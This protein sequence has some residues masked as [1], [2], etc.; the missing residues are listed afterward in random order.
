MIKQGCLIAL[1][2]IAGTIQPAAA[3]RWSHFLPLE[4]VR[5]IRYDSLANVYWL[6]TDNN[7]LWRFD[8]RQFEHFLPKTPE[9]RIINHVT[10]LTIDAK[11]A[12]L[13]VGT[14]DGLFRYHFLSNQWEYFNQDSGLSKNHVTAL[15][16]DR[17]GTLWYG[18]EDSNSS[19]GGVGK[20]DSTGWYRY[21]TAGY[22][23]WNPSDRVWVHIPE[24]EPIPSGPAARNNIDCIGQ[25]DSDKMYFGTRGT[26][27]CILDNTTTAWDTCFISFPPPARFYRYIQAIAIDRQG[28]KWLGT[29]E[30]V[31]RLNRS[32]DI[33]QC[34]TPSNSGLVEKTVHA[35]WIETYRDGDVKWFGTSW[36]VSVLDSTN[37]RWKT[38]TNENSGLGSNEVRDI[39]GDNDG[40]L[41]FASLQSRGVSKLNNNWSELK[42]EDGLRSN[43]TFAVAKDQLG[44]LWVGTDR[45]GVEILADGNW[46]KLML[47]YAACG[48]EADALVS[49]F[50]PDRAGMWVATKGCGIFR[51]ANDLSLEANCRIATNN[52]VGFPTNRVSVI[53]V[54]ND[55]LWAG[56]EDGLFRFLV[57]NA[58]STP[59]KLDAHFLSDSDVTTLAYDATGRLW[60]GTEKGLCFFNGSQCNA[61]DLPPFVRDIAINAIARDSTDA[62]WVG[63]SNGIARFAGAAWTR[64]TTTDGLPD[65][66][67]SAIG[68]A[69]DGTVW[70]GT[71]N[72]VAAFTGD[73]WTAYI[74][75]NGLSDNFILD[76]AFGPVDV[77]WF[78]TWGGG[79]ARFRKKTDAVPETYL[80]EIFDIVTETNVTFR[81]SGY[82]V[83]TPRVNL[84]YQYALDDPSTWSFISSATNV[85][86]PITRDGLHTFY[87]R[88][89]DGDGNVD[90]SPAKLHFHK[91]RLQQGGAVTIIDSARVQKYGSL[92]LYVPPHAL[93]ASAAIRVT[94]VEIDPREF[95]NKGNLRFAGIAY[96]LGPAEVGILEK[97]PL[98]MKI[99]YGDSLAAKVDEQK[100]IIYRREGGWIPVG[101]SID[102]RQH[103]ISTTIAQLDTFALLEESGT[104]I[105]G[106]ELAGVRNLA[107]QP[108][109]FSP[110]GNTFLEKATISFALGQPAEV[111][112]KIYNLAGRLVKVLCESH[113]MNLGRNAIDW[114]GRDFY[115]SICPS[116]LYVICVEAGGRVEPKNVM[117]VNR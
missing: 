37:Q 51:V 20:K 73:R 35:I 115:G 53:A 31:C 43:F 39:I 46:K 23:K 2:L 67:I 110:Q 71:I 64:F 113:P 19:G 48:G 100:L 117:V 69:A 11:K 87:V 76:L 70:C 57:S 52:P 26:G 94:P 62:M 72:G 107:V 74:T 45:G 18:S 5:R 58:C 102:A 96:S 15:F 103:A 9:G 84:R 50:L 22:F 21:T 1:T 98:T 63:T 90:G 88:A 65:D 13:W 66:R 38:F 101:G 61:N 83:S 106:A 14:T 27:L 75:D 79:I 116:G 93:Q 54:R 24:V 25:D 8:G 41:W 109:V 3:G 29:R 28:N 68:A 33:L 77:V 16:V 78:A 42:T 99:F 17:R 85:T 91:V 59:I 36:G 12:E 105:P 92:W 86:L 6:G 56:T 30:G 95:A 111:T 34:Y 114:D 82:D 108:R 89:I 10:A 4:D 32:N 104:V 80:T 7:G 112:A 60:V 40:S 81:Y 49:D 44:R 97:R 55:T 47:D